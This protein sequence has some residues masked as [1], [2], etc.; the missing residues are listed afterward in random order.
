MWRSQEVAERN[1]RGYRILAG[2][3]PEEDMPKKPH[4][5][6]TREG[7]SKLRKIR[8][9]RR[10]DRKDKNI[11]L[12]AGIQPIPM[13]PAED[14]P[15]SSPA[16]RPLTAMVGEE[17]FTRQTNSEDNLLHIVEG[18]IDKYGVRNIMDAV[19]HACFLKADHISHSWQDNRTA[20]VWKTAG[21]AVDR[22][23]K[24]MPL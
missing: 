13:Q 16:G 10:K 6:Q 22:V 12:P 21:D 3:P 2:F 1:M 24:R 17:F 11:S 7:R 23:G 20:N 8:A 5:T 4:W 14:M 9:T 19:S 18:L 15:S